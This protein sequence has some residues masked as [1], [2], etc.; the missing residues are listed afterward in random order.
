MASFYQVK[1]M[2]IEEFDR[3]L[4]RQPPCDK[5]Y[6][7]ALWSMPKEGFSGPVDEREILPPPSRVNEERK[8]RRKAEEA[9]RQHEEAKNRWRV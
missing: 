5:R 1:A 6:Y 3:F 2:S 9:L 7:Q 8:M 4:D